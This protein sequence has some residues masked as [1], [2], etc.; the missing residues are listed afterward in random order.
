MPAVRTDRFSIAGFVTFSVQGTEIKQNLQTK[1]VTI[2]TEY[3]IHSTQYNIHITQYT[4][5]INHILCAAHYTLH[6]FPVY[7]AFSVALPLSQISIKS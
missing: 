4:M 6:N 2:G 5:L 3:K 7:K 1:V